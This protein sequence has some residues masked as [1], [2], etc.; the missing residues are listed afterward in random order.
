MSIKLRR[1]FVCDVCGKA[2]I[3]T[4]YYRTRGLPICWEEINK[5][6]LCPS[7]AVNFEAIKKL[8]EIEKEKE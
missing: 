4:Y 7:C 5:K 8:T 2:G 3:P 1:V 6:H